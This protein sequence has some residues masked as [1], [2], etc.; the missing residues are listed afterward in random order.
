MVG[1]VNPCGFAMLPAYLGLYLGSGDTDGRAHLLGH[2]GRALVVG[3]LV[4]AGFV[5]MFGV[6]GLVNGIGSRSVVESFRGLA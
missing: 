6:A 1:A 4:T 2:I 5:L 3:G